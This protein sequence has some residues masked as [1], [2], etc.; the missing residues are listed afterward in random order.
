[1]SPLDI[2][3]YAR[4]I[5]DPVPAG[6]FASVLAHDGV[7]AGLAKVGDTWVVALR[8][9]ANMD[10]WV[11]DFAA[12]PVWHRQLGFCHAGFLDEMDDV[13]A[14][15]RAVVSGKVVITGHSLGGAR[16]RILA[17]LFAYN[18]IPV[19]TLCVFGSPK[20]AFTN[21]ARIIQKSG[22]THLSY[23]NRNDIVPSVPLTI[24]PFLDF[25]HTEDWMALNAEPSETN[26]EPLRDH[27]IDLYIQGLSTV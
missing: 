12:I 1:M 4:G 19:D 3:Q 16:A 23:R 24:E 9:S 21:L 22:M 6:M 7:V 5:Y 26:L 15:V 8:G 10:D 25:V 18:G 14:A 20:P 2:C 27:S 11:H 13:F 17:A